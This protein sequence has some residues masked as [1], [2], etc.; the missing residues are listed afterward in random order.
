[1]PAKADV[2]LVDEYKPL[3]YGFDG[4]RVGLKPSDHALGKVV[5]TLPVASE[6]KK[7]K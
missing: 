2:T 6:A 4:F 1:M 3:F 7:K 5:P